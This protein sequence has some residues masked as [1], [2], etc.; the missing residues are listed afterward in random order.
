VGAT[1]EDEPILRIARPEFGPAAA[2]TIT[3][4]D[5]DGDF[6]RFPAFVARVVETRLSD[7]EYDD[8]D[9]SYLVRFSTDRPDAVRRQW[10]T[11][12]AE[13]PDLWDEAE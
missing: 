11:L 1:T 12:K 4:R 6:A 3:V 13:H 9:G 5:I 2:E 7:G 10:R 8:S